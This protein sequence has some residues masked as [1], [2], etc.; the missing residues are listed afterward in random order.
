MKTNIILYRF[1]IIT[2]ISNGIFL[3]G[4]NCSNQNDY[5]R[6]SEMNVIELI[7]TVKGDNKDIVIEDTDYKILKV[8]E[9]K[10]IDNYYYSPDR[11]NY[12]VER[13]KVGNGIEI[14][15]HKMY[16]TYFNQKD[17]MSYASGYFI[18]F[19][20]NLSPVPVIWLNNEEVFRVGTSTP[21]VLF[22][23][24]NIKTG[25]DDMIDNE[26]Y[27][28]PYEYF[29]SAFNK[30]LNKIASMVNCEGDDKTYIYDLN[31]E[32]WSTIYSF[33][34]PYEE[35]SCNCAWDINNNLYFDTANINNDQQITHTI[36]RYNLK[37]SIVEDFLNN[38]TIL[39]VSPDKKYLAYINI[40][41]QTTQVLDIK[42]NNKFTV[43]LSK[44]LDWNPNKNE[45]AVVDSIK[46][47]IYSIKIEGQSI[48]V[49]RY[50]INDV[51]K[52]GTNVINL[53]YMNRQI[54]FDIVKYVFVHD[55]I[56]DID[57]V[58]TYEIKENL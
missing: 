5:L 48:K 46:N 35:Y 54:M 16:S 9:G 42:Y 20:K 23:L 51:V 53:R 31:D 36:K 18:K 55:E 24:T 10:T 27:L 49:K 26:D 39:N 40:N 6:D 28:T 56:V 37:T 7:E 33:N 25:K 45:F 1:L 19:E 2:I 17:G 34:N 12:F 47:N 29:N 15:P 32:S 14:G 22:Y 21:S 43:T 8:C 4:C 50:N 41:S 11:T 13:N 38:S 44:E 58:I 3:H 52:E 30:E 57:N